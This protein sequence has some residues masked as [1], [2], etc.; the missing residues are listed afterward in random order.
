M[1][2]FFLTIASFVLFSVVCVAHGE[3]VRIL[4]TN[5]MHAAIDKMPQLAPQPAESLQHMGEYLLSNCQWYNH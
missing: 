1:K 5:D 4:S 2:K 3:T